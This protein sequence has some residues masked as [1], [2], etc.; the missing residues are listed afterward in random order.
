MQIAVADAP[1]R[2][3][4]RNERAV[5]CQ[6][7]CKQLHLLLRAP[8][9]NVGVKRIVADVQRSDAAAIQRINQLANATHVRLSVVAFELVHLAR[10][11]GI[12][13]V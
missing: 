9:L 4:Q 12:E 5:R 7:F 11:L 1:S 10:Q 8:F 3:A 13:Q 6:C 2:Y